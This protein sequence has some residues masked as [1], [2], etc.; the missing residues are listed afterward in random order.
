MKGEPEHKMQRCPE[1]HMKD[2]DK[3]KPEKLKKKKLIFTTCFCFIKTFV[4]A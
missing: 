1:T 3:E 2:H 4:A